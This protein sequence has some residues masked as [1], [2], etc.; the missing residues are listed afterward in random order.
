LD[1][2]GEGDELGC[3]LVFFEWFLFGNDCFD[4]KSPLL[5]SR[6]FTLVLFSFFDAT[7]SLLEEEAAEGKGFLQT[8][9]FIS[10]L[11]AGVGALSVPSVPNSEAGDRPDPDA[12][13]AAA[14]TAAALSFVLIFHGLVFG[15][16]AATGTGT[17]AATGAAADDDADDAADDDTD[18]DFNSTTF[19]TAVPNPS[20]IVL[21]ELLLLL[22]LLLPLPPLLLFMLLAAFDN[23]LLILL[24]MLLLLLLL[25]LVVNTVL[26]GAT[27]AVAISVATGIDVLPSE[28]VPMAAIADH[29]FILGI[30]CWDDNDD[31]ADGPVATSTGEETDFLLNDDDDDDVVVAGFVELIMDDLNFCVDFLLST[32]VFRINNTC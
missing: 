31:D 12:T 13:V 23:L 21:D 18:E 19:F 15:I 2:C 16:G 11:S 5:L 25:L 22:L 32:C 10:L 4:E 14:P 17:T 6:L 27:A 24:F 20:L 28:D 29:D 30:D 8:G 7:L 26:G 9:P 1:D 3:L